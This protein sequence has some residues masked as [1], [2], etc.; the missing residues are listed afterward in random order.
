[1]NIELKD[2]DFKPRVLIISPYYNRENAVTKTILSILDQTYHDICV[3]IWDDCSTDGTAKVLKQIDEELN[4]PR[5]NI[6]YYKENVGLTQ[7]LNN[8]FLAGD[9]EY[10]AVVGS[11]DICLPQRIEKQIEALD[12]DPNSVLCGTNSVSIDEITHQKFFDDKFDKR[13]VTYN[14]LLKVVPFTHGSVMYRREAVI[15]IGLYE[16]IFKWCADWDLFLRLLNSSHAIYLEE[17]LYE[18]YARLDGVSFAPKKSIEQ[19]NYR[20][21]VKHL[22]KNSEKRDQIIL[23]AKDNINSILD[24]Y[25][26]EISNV[27]WKRQIKLILMGRREQAEEMFKIIDSNFGISP[28]KRVINYLAIIASYLPININSLINSARKISKS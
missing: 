27:A 17:V 3:L 12:N 9:F 26:E 8:A 2:L 25:S 16:T 28:V 24:E 6:H 4:D 5:L 20:Y 14:D 7:G 22:A 1:M 23:Q 10:V 13:I 19:I 21:L 18:R 11:G 15:K